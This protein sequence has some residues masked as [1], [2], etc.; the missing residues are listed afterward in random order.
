MLVRKVND[1]GILRD[2]RSE[3]QWE[4]ANDREFLNDFP[5]DP[6]FKSD[7]NHKTKCKN[8]NSLIAFINLS[9]VKKNLRTEASDSF[10]NVI[11]N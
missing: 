8:I 9:H 4:K 3:F 2:F 5:S 1:C 11:K 7:S 6:C 10:T